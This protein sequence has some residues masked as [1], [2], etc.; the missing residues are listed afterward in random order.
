MVEFRLSMATGNN[1]AAP[2]LSIVASHSHQQVAAS[3]P[4]DSTIRLNINS[5]RRLVDHKD[6][7]VFGLH[8]N[9]VNAVFPQMFARSSGLH[10]KSEPNSAN[11]ALYVC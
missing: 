3:A 4:P 8:L 10:S 5:R 1:D 7:D 11:A 9:S 6:A 2:A